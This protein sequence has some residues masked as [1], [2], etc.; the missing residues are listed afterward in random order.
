M[1]NTEDPR[2]GSSVKLPDLDITVRTKLPV[3]HKFCLYAGAHYL[4]GFGVECFEYDRVECLFFLVHDHLQQ[5][6]VEV[7]CHRI[8]RQHVADLVDDQQA[9]I[10]QLGPEPQVMGSTPSSLQ[11]ESD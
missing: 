9:L 8:W 7:A 11:S 5:L 3:T 4:F 1:A 10:A 6:F 2:I